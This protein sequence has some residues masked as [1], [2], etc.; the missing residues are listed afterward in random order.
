MN[1]ELRPGD[2]FA[3][4]FKCS[5]TAR[6]RDEAV[7]VFRHQSFSFVHRINDMKFGQTLVRDFFDG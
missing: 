1:A 6:Q 4:F 2:D 7:G 5:E 3:K